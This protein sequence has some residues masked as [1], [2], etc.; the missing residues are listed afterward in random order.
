MS[1]AGLVILGFGGHARS[2]AD[3]AL[4][5]GWDRLQFYDIN[6]RPDEHFNG[7][8]ATGQLPDRLPSGWSFFLG[9]GDNRARENQLGAFPADRLATLISPRSYIGIAA[10]VG[11]GS[12]VTHSAHLGPAARVGQGVIINTGAIIDHETCVGDFSHISVGATLAGRCRVGRRVM[13]GVGA[14]VR[15]GCSI[16]DDIIVGVGSVVVSDLLEPGVYLGLPAKLL[17]RDLQK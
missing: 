3:I 13:V 6:A 10:S 8:P 4:R 1:Q 14:S 2:V 7:F 5:S 16:G 17:R 11:V 12:L 9:A 15:D